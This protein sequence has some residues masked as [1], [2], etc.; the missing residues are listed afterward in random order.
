MRANTKFLAF[1]IVLGL[2]AGCSSFAVNSDFDQSAN[3]ADYQTFNFISDK[4]LLVADIAGASPLLPGRLMKAA[5]K[6]LT[7]KGFRFVDDR[8]SADFVISFTLGARDKIRVTSY[9]T[10]YRRGA[11]VGGWGAPYYN[12]VDVRNYTEGTLSIDLFDVQTRKPVWHGWAVKS[13]TSADREN[14]EPLINEIVE[15]ILAEFPP[16]AG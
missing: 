6:E 12:E 5:R 10:T 14:P 4:P 9:P 8:A 3:F 2:A 11:Y 16:T 1:A 15:A 7:A 13:I